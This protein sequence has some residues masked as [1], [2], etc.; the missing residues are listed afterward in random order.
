MPTLYRDGQ[1]VDPDRVEIY[2]KDFVHRTDVGPL[3]P[4][5]RMLSGDVTGT[6]PRPDLQQGA[7]WECEGAEAS[8][9]IPAGCTGEEIAVRVNFP[10]CWNGRD[11][12][13]PDHLGHMA[14]STFDLDSF[15]F[16]CPASH[17][18]HVPAVQVNAI[19]PL[20]D[21]TG[22]TVASGAP[23]TAH[24]DF[25]SAWRPGEQER[26]VVDALK[27]NQACAAGICIPLPR[28]P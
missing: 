11:L 23:N 26:L 27:N 4:G 18:V 5:L 1:V 9:S 19:Y 12:D 20:P 13:S 17:P 14:Y 28:I 3:P 22:V 7:R 8:A 25:F 15:A 24:A 6:L 21:G 16:A 10:D 2:Y